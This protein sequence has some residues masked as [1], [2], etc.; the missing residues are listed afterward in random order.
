[1][2]IPVLSSMVTVSLVHFM[3]NL[4]CLLVRL[5]E[6][7]PLRMF[8]QRKTA[9]RARGFSHL[10]SFMVAG[11]SAAFALY[12]WSRGVAGGVVRCC[13]EDGDAVVSC[14]C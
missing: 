7:L 3:R 9:M 8:V 5:A 11:G 2:R 1:M 12:W 6:M 14:V 13:L 4:P 10:T